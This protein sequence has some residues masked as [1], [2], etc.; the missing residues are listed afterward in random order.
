MLLLLLALLSQQSLFES[1][2]AALSAGD[3]PRAEQ[4][5]KAVLKVSPKSL[6]A[7]ANL[8]VV[9]SKMDRLVDAIDVYKQA[10]KLSPGEPK[11]LLNLGLAHLKLEDHSS[12]KPLFAAVLNKQPQNLQARELLGTTQ[13]FAG[14]AEAGLS[15]LEPLP[16]NPGVLYLR[17]LAQLKMKNREQAMQ[18]SALLFARV[19]P[20]EASFLEGRAY[21]ESALFE[22]A[23]KSLDHA[24]ELDAALAGVQR[25]LGK[26]YVSLRNPTAAKTHLEAALSRNPYDQEAAYFLGALLV[27]ERENEAGI[28][29]LEQSRKTRPDFWGAHYYLGKARLQLG[30]VARA[31]PLLERAAS[32][33]AGE[34]SIHYLLAQALKTAG[35]DEESRRASARMKELRAKTAVKER[36]ALVLR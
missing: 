36:E 23:A 18:T 10:L 4:E 30:D 28:R 27:Q 5:F 29:Y 33:N 22:E 11:L 25:E 32:L 17:M 34:A 7:L 19:S 16:G 26:T 2:L 12:A 8:G 9:Y 14:E 1:A 24:A 6:P 15:T 21:Y 20:A 31:L 35:R 3:L 13:V